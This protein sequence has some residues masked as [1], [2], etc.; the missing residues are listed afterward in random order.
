MKFR[1]LNRRDFISSAVWAA[2][3][4]VVATKTSFAAETIGETATE[5][6]TPS[7]ILENRSYP[8]PRRPLG[9]TGALVSILC[10][11]GYHIGNPSLT[12]DEAISM[13]RRAIDE[14]VNFFDNAWKYHD[15]R[16]EERM[17][18]ALKDGYRDKVFLMTKVVGRDRETAQ[19]QLEDCLRRL[20]VDVIDLLQVHEVVRPS[21]VTNV[22][23]NGVLDVF[24]KAKEEG[25]IRH[26]GVTGHNYPLFLNQMLE[27][28]FPFETIQIPLNAF[29]YH[30]RSFE[31]ETL[32]EALKR[33]IGVI[34]MKT[35]GGT[36]AALP[37]SG[38]LTPAECL[39]YAMSLPVSSVCSGMNRPEWLEH[40]LEVARKFTPMSLEEREALLARTQPYAQDGK[41]ETYKTAWHRDVQ[42]EMER[43]NQQAVG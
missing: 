37:K 38:A 22:Y 9:K 29:D 16:S 4:G 23:E 39:R 3:G 17:G 31:R 13:M 32:P 6:G 2:V 7:P 18:R 43:L 41:H 40:N 30:Y 36:P 19:R 11:G 33:G 24:I 15:G 25:K 28:G 1:S 42:E 34:A 35:M 21:D 20:D 8:I 27:R 10:L 12:D 26:I 5:K 14:G